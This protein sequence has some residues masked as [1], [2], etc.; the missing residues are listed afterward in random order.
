M[1]KTL[2]SIGSIIDYPTVH[3]K[4]VIGRVEVILKN[5]ILIR[6]KFEQTHLVLIKTVEKDGFEVDEET[7]IYKNRYSKK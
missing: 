1:S 4:R 6:D 2:V 3:H 7:Y 5:T